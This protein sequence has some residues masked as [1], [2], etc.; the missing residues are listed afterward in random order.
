[1][2]MASCSQCFLRPAV[3]KTYLSRRRGFV[4]MLGVHL[5]STLRA[6]LAL[7]L[8]G[9][10]FN[11]EAVVIYEQLPGRNSPEERISSTLNNFGNPPGFRTADNFALGANFIIAD[12]HWWGESNSGGNDFSFTFYADGGGVPGAILLTTGGSLSTQTVNVGS[13]FDPVTFYSSD[14]TLPFSAIGGTTYWISIFN[15]AA[16]ASWLWLSANAP[17]DGGRQGTNPGP[18]WSTSTPDLAFQLTSLQTVPEPATVGL[19]GI[20]LAGLGFSRRKRTVN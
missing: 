7:I 19:L 20:A 9:L 3:R 5:R 4:N 1:M 16:D 6:T 11:A 15:Q 12:V 8:F 2:T 18:P 10:A 13:S 17:G 14:L